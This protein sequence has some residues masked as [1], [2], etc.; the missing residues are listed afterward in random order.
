VDDTDKLDGRHC[1]PLATIP[2]MGR[3]TFP[4]F[5][6]A[7]TPRYVVMWDLHWHVIDCQRLAPAAD[8]SGAM[9]AAVDR[10]VSDGWEVESTPEYGFIF[11]RRESERRLLNADTARSVQHGGAIVHAVSTQRG[12]TSKVTASHLG[13]IIPFGVKRSVAM[14]HSSIIRDPIPRMFLTSSTYHFCHRIF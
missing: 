1:S 2:R 8:L 12:I 9:T 5:T 7:T 13:R 14:E 11:V 6:T 3:Y 10:L 4:A